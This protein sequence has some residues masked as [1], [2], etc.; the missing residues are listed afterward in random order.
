MGTARWA[1][2]QNRE[3]FAVPGPVDYAGSR[4][5]HKLIREGAALVEGVEDILAE[6]PELAEKEGKDMAHEGSGAANERSGACRA[7]RAANASFTDEERAVLSALDLNPKHIDDLVQFCDISPT[8]MLPLLLGLEMRGV[9]ESCGGGT[10][11]LAA[12]G[13]RK[14]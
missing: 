3:V 5:P 12:A 13:G 10:Y 9:I 7:N 8:L 6:L 11:A 2:E 4:G 1:L 14:V